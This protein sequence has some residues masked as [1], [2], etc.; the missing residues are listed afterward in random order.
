MNTLRY[1]LTC[2]PHGAA[3]AYTT[4]PD[5]SHGLLN[6][7]CLTTN[8]AHASTAEHAR[9]ELTANGTPQIVGSYREVA[10]W[11]ARLGAL[12]WQPVYDRAQA[13]PTP[14]QAQTQEG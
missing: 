12:D 13:I 7:R 14:P 6:V 1:A 9:Y 2:S 3:Y 10:S 5:G 11:S 4:R 8:A